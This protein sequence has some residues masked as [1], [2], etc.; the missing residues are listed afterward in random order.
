VV[1][2]VGNSKFYYTADLQALG[3][4]TTLQ[5]ISGTSVTLT[6][7]V[8]PS[9]LKQPVTFTATVASNNGIVPTGTLTFNDG[10]K[11]LGTST[12]DP[13]G[14]ATFTIATLSPGTHS[15]VASYS[16]D[17]NYDPGDSSPLSQGVGKA[18]SRTTVVS[19]RNPS[20]FGAP[21]TFTA[22][23]ESTVGTPLDGET[24][25][26][27]DNGRSLG[28]ASLVSGIASLTTTKL[29]AG[30]HRIEARYSGDPRR[31]ESTSPP[32]GQLVMQP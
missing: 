27:T 17:S 6:S 14:T 4:P 29:T 3:F 21:V 7:S 8:N 15:I 12:L 2:N 18:P 1:D 28:S 23:V 31:Q 16:G 11:T 19:S 25:I 24:V 9:A 13:T 22:T 30:A 26:F 10:N 32:L 5:V 20:R